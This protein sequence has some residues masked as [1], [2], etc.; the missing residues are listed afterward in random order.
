MRNR[1]NKYRG[2]FFPPRKVVVVLRNFLLFRNGL[3]STTIKWREIKSGR[4]RWGR[5]S[6]SRDAILTSDADKIASNLF[7]SFYRSFILS[8]FIHHLKL[9][10]TP[11]FFFFSFF[12]IFRFYFLKK[13]LSFKFLCFFF[14]G[15]SAS[16]YIFLF[17]PL[18]S[19]RLVL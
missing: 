11:P 15:R 14:F 2:K 13:I 1:S 8:S 9:F 10:R 17:H 16:S 12:L 19:S 4:N 6:I 5:K 18:F 3:R 7:R